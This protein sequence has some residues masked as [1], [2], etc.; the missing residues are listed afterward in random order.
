MNTSEF[1]QFADEYEQL[2]ARNLAVTGEKPEFFHQYKIRVLEQVVRR[3]G[4]D[5]RAILDFGSGIGNSTRFLRQY[6][7]SAKLASADISQRSL[8]VANTRLPAVSETL[9]IDGNRIPAADNSFDVAFSACVF[10]HIPHEEHV[11]W[12]TELRR[13]TRAGGMLVIFEHNPLNPLTV[14]AVNSCPFDENAHLIRAVDFAQIYRRSGWAN[15]KIR[16]HLFFPHAL[17]WLRPCEHFLGALPVGGQ[18]SV[19]AFKP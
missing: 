3:Q 19:A 4:L 1:D 8:D 11:H 15:P 16:F 7:P 13:V 5:A 14:R 9:R 6:F 17:A 10:H 18:Y 2:H 12:L